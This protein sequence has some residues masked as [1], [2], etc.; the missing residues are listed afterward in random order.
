MDQN[1]SIRLKQKVAELV[2]EVVKGFQAAKGWKWD[3]SDVA[4]LIPVS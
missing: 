3:A 2:A 4:Y 1:A